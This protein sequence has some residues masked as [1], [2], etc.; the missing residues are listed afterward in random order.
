MKWDEL[1]TVLRTADANRCDALIREEIERGAGCRLWFLLRVHA[2][3]NRVRA[4]A[5]RLVYLRRVEAAGG[6]INPGDRDK[7]RGGRHE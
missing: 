7:V 2:R 3:L 6:L 4:Q 5:E 1:N